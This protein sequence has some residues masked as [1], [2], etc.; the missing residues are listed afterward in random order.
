MA[1]CPVG[2]DLSHADGQTGATKLTFAC[3]NFASLPK[4]RKIVYFATGVQTQYVAVPYKLI[5]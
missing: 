5:K 3:R 4:T 2:D 1:I